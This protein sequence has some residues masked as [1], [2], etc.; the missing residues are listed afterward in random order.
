MKAAA[1]MV[2][3]LHGGGFVEGTPNDVRPVVS[4]LRDR[5]V[6][7]RAPRYPLGQGLDTAYRSVLGQVRRY[8]RHGYRVVMY[9]HSAGASMALWLAATHRVP[10]VAMN[11]VTDFVGWRLP[12]AL[13]RKKNLAWGSYKTQRRLS[14]LVRLTRRSGPATVVHSV[15][16][17]LAPYSQSQKYQSRSRRLGVRTKLVA[18]RTGHYPDNAQAVASVLRVIK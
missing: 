5:G 10:A 18:T 4:S 1:V 12:D 6:H 7:V 2:L 15:N 11:P 17:P 13:Q 3:A 8:R 16:D 14:P 9:G